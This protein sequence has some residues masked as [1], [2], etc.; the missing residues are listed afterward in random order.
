MLAW[1]VANSLFATDSSTPDL[2]VQRGNTAQGQIA[3]P[4]FV[5]EVT[6]VDLTVPVARE[7]LR[8]H[9]LVMW[10][11]RCVLHRATIFDKTK[12]RCV[13]HRTTVAGRVP[14]S[15]LAHLPESAA[16]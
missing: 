11:N 14:D 13:M 6:G 15:A 7:D 3:P 12:Y 2:H 5:A 8:L 9:N 4:L 16:A 10:D 1:A